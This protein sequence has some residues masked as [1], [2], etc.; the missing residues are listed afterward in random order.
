MK[1]LKKRPIQVDIWFLS[2]DYTS[3][4]TPNLEAARF[5][6]EGFLP[7]AGRDYAANRNTDT[8]SGERKNVS[9]WLRFQQQQQ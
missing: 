5:A 9:Q 3:M 2:A 1:S 4:Y 7:R 8:G 6:L